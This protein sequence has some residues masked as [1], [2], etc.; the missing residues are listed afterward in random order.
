[1][2][3]I[4]VRPSKSCMY[5]NAPEANSLQLPHVAGKLLKYPFQNASNRL[6]P[7]IYNYFVKF[8]SNSSVLSPLA[9]TI[10][11][12]KFGNVGRCICNKSASVSLLLLLLSSCQLSVDNQFVCLTVLQQIARNGMELAGCRFRHAVMRF[13]AIFSFGF[14]YLQDRSSSP[15]QAIFM[16]ASS[17][18]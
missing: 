13:D 5:R 4:A 8:Y 9:K 3:S 15:L 2:G 10:R 14:A 16:P 7:M 11:S 1:M 18:S 12:V 17:T 6:V